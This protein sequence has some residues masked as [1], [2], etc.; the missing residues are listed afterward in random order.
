[1]LLY[2]NMMAINSKYDFE[3]YAHNFSIFNKKIDK[4]TN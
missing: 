1:M 4:F 2:R 3:L